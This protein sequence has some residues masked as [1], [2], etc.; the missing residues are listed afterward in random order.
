MTNNA[1]IDK[2]KHLIKLIDESLKGIEIEI[3]KSLNGLY[4]I[5]ALLHLQFIKTAL[6]NMKIN[7]NQNN[8]EMIAMYN[9]N[10]ARIVIDTW[11]I[12]NPLGNQICEIEYL[13]KKLR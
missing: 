13:Y 4:A 9:P 10:I 8:T 1:S 12:D 5:D 11:P 6:T 7:L 2:N 3:S